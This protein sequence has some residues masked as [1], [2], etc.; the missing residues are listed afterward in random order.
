[1]MITPETLSRHELTGLPVEV[2]SAA[3]AD[4][5]GIRGLVVRETMNTVVIA[6]SLEESDDVTSSQ[7][8][9]QGTTFAFT[10]DD[11][12]IIVDGDQLVARP[13][14]RTRSGGVSPWV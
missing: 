4:L 7:V 11:E 12:T 2:R 14:E 13:A 8:P 1:M 9:K 3:N 10:V 5:V 6:P